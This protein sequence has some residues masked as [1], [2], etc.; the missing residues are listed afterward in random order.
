MISIKSEREIE[1]MRKAGKIMK[2]IHDELAK[3]IKPGITTKQLDKV[4]NNIIEKHGAISGEYMYPSPVGLDPFPGHACI[5]VND[6]IIHG[7][8]GDRILK[9]GDIV[10]ID[11]VIEKDGYCADAART[12]AVGKI[13]K[14]AEKLI[15]VTKKSFF[16]AMK[17]AKEGAR[18]GDISNAIEKFVKENGFDVIHEYQG[19]GIGSEMHEEP[20]IPNYGKAGKG[21]RLKKGMTLAIEPMVVEGSRDI[22]DDDPDGWTVRTAD[23]KLAA[24]YENTIVITDGEPEILTI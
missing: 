5:S 2:E 10:S 23:G 14:N 4:I 22:L 20:G 15:K 1:L 17:V 12:Y 3:A 19:H 21:P 11:L 6:E 24:H 18:I 13:S 9:E 16:Q 8:P 7:V